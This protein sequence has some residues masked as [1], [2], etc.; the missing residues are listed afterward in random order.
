LTKRRYH[1]GKRPPPHTHTNTNQDRRT[2][3]NLLTYL[4]AANPIKGKK[5]RFGSSKGVSEKGGL[6]QRGGSVKVGS[7]NPTTNKNKKEKKGKNKGHQWKTGALSTQ[8][9][10]ETKRE[11]CG[12]WPV[13]RTVHGIKKGGKG[14]VNCQGKIEKV[15]KVEKETNNVNARTVSQNKSPFEGGELDPHDQLRR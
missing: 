1:C 6:R 4:G 8:K 5:T 15:Q 7:S 10:T 12:V 14:Q 13:G 3:A 11:I 2:A 9:E